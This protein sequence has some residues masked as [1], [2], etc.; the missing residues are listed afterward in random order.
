MDIDRI[1]A[2]L[3]SPNVQ[4]RLKGLT[5]LRQC[6]SSEIAVPMLKSKLNDPEFLVRSFVAMGLGKQQTDASFKALQ[7]L[8]QRDRDPNVR[9][10]AA[11]SLSLFGNNA[12]P[13]LMTA[14]EQDPHWLL[15]RS[16]LAAIAE[17]NCPKE[18][19]QICLL[20]IKGDDQ[21][22]RESAIDC[23]GLLVN[24]EAEGPALQQ[25]LELVDANGWRTR[26]RV[27]ITLKKFNHPQAQEALGHLRQDEN[28]RVV[29][30]ALEGLL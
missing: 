27:A 18:L 3:Q 16:I 29:G 26:W 28:H 22:V 23:L 9:A 14:F 19:L 11:N 20:A 4:E 25:L 21:S 2:Y 8:L 13:D 15:R 7:Q 12:I 1:E 6:D 10:E 17:M 24:T 5:E 30:A